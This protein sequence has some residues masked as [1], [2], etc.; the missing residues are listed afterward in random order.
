MIAGEK[1][2][3]KWQY[4]TRRRGGTGKRL[5][6]KFTSTKQGRPEGI[7]PRSS[8]AYA[9]HMPG[10]PPKNTRKRAFSLRLEKPSL[11]LKAPKNLCTNISPHKIKYTQQIGNQNKNKA[12]RNKLGQI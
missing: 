9:K 5:M 7:S 4:S 12:G 1:Q 8:E 3:V 11:P 2:K 10:S 6:G